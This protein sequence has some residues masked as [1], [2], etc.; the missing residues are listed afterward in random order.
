MTTRRPGPQ[1]SRPPQQ[2]GPQRPPARRGPPPGPRGAT[3]PGATAAPPPR[4]LRPAP[5]QPGAVSLPDPVGVQELAE[6]L[7]VSGIDVV[8]QL[9]RN[10]V[11][12]NLT[13]TVDFETAALVARDLGFTPRAEGKTVGRDLAAMHHQAL[14]P[15]SGETLIERPPVVTI[16]GHVDHGKTTLLDAIRSTKV[17]EGEAGGITQHIGAYQV[18]AKGRPITFLDTPGHAAFTAMR[19][20][21]AGVTDIAVLV[22]AADDGVM[23]QTI[24]AINHAKAAGVPI[25]VAVN[26]IDKPGANPD[27]VKLQLNEHGL[28]LEEWGGEVIAVPVSAKVGTGIEDLLDNILVVAEVGELRA[29]PN[30]LAAG[31]VIEAK[32]DRAKG[33]VATI[34]VQNGTLHLGDPVVAGDAWGRVKAMLDDT[35]KRVKEAGPSVPVEV[36]GLDGLPRAGDPVLAFPDDAKARAFVQ[37][38]Q[39]EREHLPTSVVHAPTLEEL[40]GKVAAGE[41]KELRIILKTDVQGSLEPVRDSLDHLTTDKSRVRLLHAGAGT[42]NESDVLL[43]AASQAM[44]LGF[45]TQVEPGA[46]SLAQSEGVEIRQYQV[47]YTLVDEIRQALEGILAPVVREVVDGHGAIRATFSIGKNKEKIAGVFINDGKVTRGAKARVLRAN[48]MLGEGNVVSLKRLK[49]DARE[50]TA[51]LECGLSIEGFT[52]FEE[53][54]TLEFSHMEQGAAIAAAR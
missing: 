41:V 34:L 39:R 32:V 24:E 12:A 21:G 46:R 2:R 48:K 42:I 25:V 18:S 11:M 22:V 20:R 10:G 17:A 52:L 40:A 16:L 47:I 33:P 15:E 38:R 50:V 49:D 3:A 5:R 35:G 28:V 51:G 4:P 6:R 27:K 14:E 37:E 7:A 45:T 36:L 1:R 53:G 29:N 23:P 30:R 13:Q 19:A 44:I 43:A 26:K 54:D 8:K 31:V 9:M